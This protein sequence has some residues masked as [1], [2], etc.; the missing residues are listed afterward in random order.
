MV[1]TSNAAVQ[2]KLPPRGNKI[3]IVDI[4]LQEIFAKQHFLLNKEV[5]RRFDGN[6]YEQGTLEQL[7]FASRATVWRGLRFQNGFDSPVCCYGFT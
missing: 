6:R 2:S 7:R 4:E 3:A 5:A 1:C